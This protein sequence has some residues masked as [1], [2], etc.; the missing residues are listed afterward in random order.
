MPQE[1]STY[2]PQT[3][4]IV[5]YLTREHLIWTNQRSI[6]EN[7]NQTLDPAQLGALNPELKYPIVYAFQH[8]TDYDP[9]H[10]RCQILLASDAAGSDTREVLLDIHEEDYEVLPLAI[11]PKSK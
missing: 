5:R 1:E 2:D 10:Y 7:F 4:D 11:V 9:P 3:E 8:G 6:E